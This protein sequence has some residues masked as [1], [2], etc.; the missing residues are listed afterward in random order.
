[1]ALELLRCCLSGVR[2][3]A[4]DALLACDAIS[5]LKPLLAKHDPAVLEGAL[6][7]LSLL[8]V[9]FEGKE[10]AVRP[11]LHTPANEPLLWRA[12]WPCC[13]CCVCR[14]RARR[15]RCVPISTPQPMNPCCGGR[16]GRA[17]AAVCAVRGQGEGG[18]SPSPHPS[19]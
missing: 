10:K 14:S 16:A 15:R 18:A 8:C 5:A 12:R 2:E 3:P 19:Q 4:V 13:R 17:V 11:H 7:V 1:M 9:P 6:A